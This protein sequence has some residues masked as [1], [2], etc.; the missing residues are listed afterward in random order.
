[1]AGCDFLAQLPGIGIK[2]AHGMLRKYRAF[3][4]VG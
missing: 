3:T 2:K 1:M 4:K